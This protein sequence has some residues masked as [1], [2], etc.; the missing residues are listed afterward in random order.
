[1][2][3][4]CSM[5]DG[6]PYFEVTCCLHLQ[7]TAANR[8]PT[9]VTTITRD[10]I[11]VPVILGLQIPGGEHTLAF[12]NYGVSKTNI[13]YHR[14]KLKLRTVIVN[15]YISPPSSSPLSDHSR[16]H[17]SFYSHQ[18]APSSLSVHI[19]RYPSCKSLLCSLST[20]QLSPLPITNCLFS[21]SGS[22]QPQVPQWPLMENKRQPRVKPGAS[23]TSVF[24]DV[25][26]K[27]SQV[28]K[29]HGQATQDPL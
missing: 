13:V 14:F 4:P 18:S 16:H 26:L 10:E 15:L 23:P 27:P 24:R 21:S 11:F 2:W 25:Y 28:S 20:L 22:S 7:G 29:A 12:M 5:V 19:T 8:R 9:D 3:L 17:H 6:Y 1:M